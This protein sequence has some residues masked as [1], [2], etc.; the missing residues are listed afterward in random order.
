MIAK[1]QFMLLVN[2][3]ANGNQDFVIGNHHHG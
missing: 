1:D 2:T 3:V